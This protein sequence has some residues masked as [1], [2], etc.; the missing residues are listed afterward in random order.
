MDLSHLYLLLKIKSRLSKEIP[1]DISEEMNRHIA[2]LK[3][4]EYIE[5]VSMWLPVYQITDKGKLRTE[6]YEEH[7]QNS[8]EEVLNLRQTTPPLDRL[9]QVK[10]CLTREQSRYLYSYEACLVYHLNQNVQNVKR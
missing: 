5:Q 3:R 7:T 10:E 6:V 9:M 2:Y 1:E 8:I 4:L